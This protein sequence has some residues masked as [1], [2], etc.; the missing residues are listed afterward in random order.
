MRP[1]SD[2]PPSA[3]TADD[4]P[5]DRTPV[6]VGV[7]L[8]SLLALGW[9][10]PWILLWTLLATAIASTALLVYFIPRFVAKIIRENFGRGGILQIW[11][12]SAAQALR[13][14]AVVLATWIPCGVASVVLFTANGLLVQWAIGLTG[15]G[16]EQLSVGLELV[17]EQ[18]R[19]TVEE[20][21]WLVRKVLPGEGAELIHALESGVDGIRGA[22]R[23]LLALLAF[24]LV[25]EGILS[26]VFLV[27]LTIRSVLYLFARQVLS[28]LA[29]HRTAGSLPRLH[30]RMGFDR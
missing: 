13:V 21:P 2:E 28:E 22:L 25:V 1:P 7:G 12:P 27:W 29:S 24:I 14:F 30:F 18:G 8:A 3:P 15:K 20:A 5:G 26:F 10:M 9:I 11:R 6:I 23:N 16:I 17:D 4:G 19:V